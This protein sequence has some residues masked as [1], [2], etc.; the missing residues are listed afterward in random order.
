MKMR[1]P[2]IPL[3]TVDPYFSI[4]SFTDKLYES[5][6]VL[7]TGQSNKMVGILTV[8]GEQYAFMSGCDGLPHLEQRSV[9]VDALSTTYVFSNEAVELT[10]VF[11]TPV[12]PYDLYLLTRPVSYLDVRCR[13]LDGK[14][15]E[16]SVSIA[17]SSEICVADNEPVVTE[18]VLLD[19]T[20]PAVKMG[21][22]TQKPLNRSG[23][24]IKI[25][26]G[27][28]WL[29][30]RGE[31]AVAKALPAC[32]TGEVFAQA[33]ADV[34]REGALF[35]FAFDDVASIE[36][37]GE[38]LRSYWNKSGETIETAIQKAYQDYEL[39]VSKSRVFSDDLKDKATRSG[40]EKYAE[41]LLLAYRQ[42]IAAHKLVLDKNGELWY[43]SKEC[44]SNG[45]AATVDVSYPSIPMFLIYNPALVQGMLRPVFHYVDKGDWAYDFAP[46][47]V[48]R[49]PLLNGQVYGERPTEG[50]MPVEECGNMILM[51]AA[52]TAAT[53]DTTYAAM[54]L[55]T[56]ESWCRY[57][58]RY[59]EDPENQLCT[60]DFAG[61]LAHNCNLSLKAIMG[62]AGL[63][64][65]YA[66]LGKA[67]KAK[68]LMVTAKRMADSWVTRA[69]NGDGSYRLAFDQ[70]GSFSMK[71]NVVW[72]GVFGFD[73]F[74][75]QVIASELAGY[76]TR[77]QP[78][79]LPL[80][81]RKTYTKSDWLVWVA[82]MAESK[83]EFEA[84]IAPLWQAYNDSPSRVPM[85]DWYETTD[86]TRLYFQHRTVQGGL[87]MKL[88]KDSGICRLS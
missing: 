36:Y 2:A 31:N 64:S 13:S 70:P 77:F 66:K 72:D 43:I 54:H 48:G 32:P 69:A 35:T 37:F 78:Y 38:W 27:Y 68:E 82:S 80:D 1:A 7:W 67:D 17:V 3:I 23:D 57:L 79:G 12:L 47:D 45:C 42:V 10:A 16:C 4:W 71:Y 6:T 86:A 62:V 5:P 18:E 41:L 11:L 28:L 30:V 33:A 65:I 22:Q 34:S 46:H 29:A 75:T 44:H 15:H 49:Y 88:L 53:N 58:I 21:A 61:H 85:G 56:L 19:G 84:F 51:C 81:S 63:A 55:E 60:D 20:I 24:G 8:D 52:L 83:D 25:D 39:C 50:Q 87:F 74:D 26:W 40:G 59:G 76:R 14:F 73:L 9:D